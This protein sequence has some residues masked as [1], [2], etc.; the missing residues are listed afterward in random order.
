VSVDF[1]VGIDST[2]SLSKLAYHAAKEWQNHIG[3]FV[4]LRDQ[5]KREWVLK[6]CEASDVWGVGRKMALH[7]ESMGIKTAW[8]LAHAD[9]WSL[10]K[11]FSVLVEKTARELAGT[12]CL[13]LDEPDPPN[14]EIC[15]SRM[16]GTRLTELTPIKEAVATY[17]SRAA[18]KLR[19]QQSLCK[20]LR[21]S[22]RTGMFN[23]DEPNTPMASW[24]NCLSRISRTRSLSSFIG[25][26]CYT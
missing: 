24:S 11:Q 26:P 1:G 6:K 25:C 23:P 9:A 4:D 10:R 16:F 13:D 14:K 22:V 18:E 15:S 3:G 5:V 8:E 19:A 20:R 12:T 2:K 21:V 17:T 7:L